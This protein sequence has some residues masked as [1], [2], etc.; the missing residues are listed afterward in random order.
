MFGFLY[1]LLLKYLSLLLV[2]GFLYSLLLKYLSLLLVFSGVTINSDAQ[3]SWFDWTTSSLTTGQVNIS[4]GTAGASIPSGNVYDAELLVYTSS[5]TKG[6]TW[7][8]VP[9]QVVG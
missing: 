1:S 9:I 3:P 5:S 6:I 2:F 8:T 4:L 7:G